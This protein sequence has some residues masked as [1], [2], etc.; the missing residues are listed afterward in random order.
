[1]RK[2]I[3]F[4]LIELLGVIVVLS[5]LA[6]L[7]I[8]VINNAL[9]NRKADLYNTQI[10]NMELALRNWGSSNI[11]FLPDEE[12][13]SMTLT[14]DQLKKSGLI[15]DN[16]SNPVTGDCF[17]NDMLFTITKEGN[18]Y[19][20]EVIEN[21]GS[22]SCDA[23]WNENS[24]IFVLRGNA[25]IYV[26]V[27]EPYV[28]PG[29]IARRPDG[30]EITNVT[31]TIKGPAPTINSSILGTYEIT[32]TA[33]DGEY[34]STL[35]RTVVVRDTIPPVI[36][37]EEVTTI[38]VL[39]P[40]FDIMDN[41]IVS[42]NSGLD[43]TVIT[44]GSMNTNVSGTYEVTYTATD[45]S[46]NRTVKRRKIIVKDAAPPTVTVTVVGDPFN[47][48]GWTN[49]DVDVRIIARDDSSGI[50]ELWYC[51]SKT[52]TCEPSTKY[53]GPNI[54]I[55]VDE[56][57]ATNYVCAY[58]VDGVNNKSNVVCAGP[59]RIDKTFPTCTTSITSG[60]MGNNS[61]YKTNVTYTGTCA[62]TGPSGCV[63]NVSATHQAN[64]TAAGIMV[65]PGTVSTK[66]GLTRSCPT[67]TFKMD[68][69]APTCTSTIT[70]GTPNSSGWYIQQTVNAQGTCKDVGSSG[71]VGNVTNSGGIGEY[72][73]SVGT[74][75]DNAG[76]STVC[77]VIPVKVS[78][79]PPTCT[80][81]ITSGTLGENGWYRSDIVITAKCHSE[82][83]SCVGNNTVTISQNGAGTWNPPQ[84]KDSSG[85]VGNCPAISYKIDKT[86]PTCSLSHVTG[87]SWGNNSWLRQGSHT[88]RANCAD[89]GGSGCVT[90]YVDD[91]R[92]QGYHGLD[93]GTPF[94]S[95]R[96][97]KDNAGNSVTCPTYGAKIDNVA[98]NIWLDDFQVKNHGGNIYARAYFGVT[99][100]VTYG[101]SLS[102]AYSYCYSRVSGLSAANI[103]AKCSFTAWTDGGTPFGLSNWNTGNTALFAL[104]F[105]YRGAD[106]HFRISSTDLA[107]NRAQTADQ[108]RSFQCC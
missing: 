82:T 87:M 15:E 26:E 89:T 88:V 44:T 58:A 18:G 71:C 74:V 45:A 23:T 66:A 56:E 4:T 107:G 32:Y 38:D 41:V 8:P 105:G 11:F 57:S 1:M 43:P 90:S 21:S 52:G 48:Y 22:A 30:T 59:I 103:G 42:D 61:W 86:S 76:N 20:Y 39:S 33:T 34:V 63:G 64:T 29:W 75:W 98:P 9:Q 99:D 10:K 83:N 14:L 102:G 62:T 53:V 95:G 7:V 79:Y 70:N 27:N 69:N 68:K 96:S 100:N 47:E 13:E 84:V 3:G 19:I 50:K 55:T 85:Q 46:G 49:T 65:S 72:N 94:H 104:S 12:G 2:K 37:L 31:Q 5:L 54:T 17:P 97:F 78:F 81:S 51:K 106:A 28:E 108:Y 6:L 77:P 60:T 40:G 35:K 93:A 73:L 25:R 92:G 36:D 24:P 80:T 67:V 16:I 101:E 91:T